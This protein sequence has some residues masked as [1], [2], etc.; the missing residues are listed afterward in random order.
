MKKVKTMT[1]FNYTHDTENFTIRV[2]TPYNKDFVNK[3]RNLKGEWEA[4]EEEWVFDDSIEEY[5][6]NALI[7]CYGTTGEEPV[8]TCSL[9]VKEVEEDVYGGPVEL[10]GR[11]IAKAWGR[12]SGARLSE[13][14][15]WISGSYSSGGSV[16]NWRTSLNKGTFIIQNFPLPRTEFPDVQ[17]AIAEG[18]CEIKTEK[19]RRSKEEI[20]SEIEKYEVIL[21]EL[22]NELNNI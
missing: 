10:F 22:K 3:A 5:V 18:W 21:T 15:V 2:K 17:E 19:K 6:K 8:K 14:I 9:L 13:G 12:D 1:G 4:K 11:R 16:K 7:K 20:Q